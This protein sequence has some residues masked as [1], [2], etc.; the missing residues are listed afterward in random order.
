MIKKLSGLLFSILI[1]LSFTVS[2]FAE[3][4]KDADPD[5]E[6]FQYIHDPMDYPSAA[7]D[8]VVNPDAIYGYSP[9]PESKRLGKF[10]DE[11]DWSDPDAVAKVREERQEYHDSLKELYTMIDQMEQENCT[12]EEIARAV[13]KRRN[14]IR[15]ESYK[16]DPEGLELMKQSNLET[17]GNENGPTIES[18][19][20]KYGSWEMIIQKALSPNAGMDACLGFYDQN[21]D[22]YVMLDQLAEKEEKAVLDTGVEPAPEYYTVVSGDSL[23]KLG[24]MYY[25]DGNKWQA[26]Y[27]LN[28]DQIREPSVIYPGMVLHMPAYGN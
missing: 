15:I 5:K 28:R 17:Y 21:Y 9:N 1:A 23:W 8:I 22:Q 11:I 13:S 3:E 16:D 12:T 2:V 4:P 24:R 6:G 18:L 7:E 27:E 26:I 10:A 19:Y 25:D 20:E 14:E